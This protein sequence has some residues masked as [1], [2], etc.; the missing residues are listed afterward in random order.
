[1]NGA[2]IKASRGIAR[3]AFR[4]GSCWAT[5]QKTLNGVGRTVQTFRSLSK[6][7]TSNPHPIYPPNK[8][9]LALNTPASMKQALALNHFFL[10]H[11]SIPRYEK[12]VRKGSEYVVTLVGTG[13]DE[14]RDRRVDRYEREWEDVLRK[15]SLR[16]VGISLVRL[17][18]MG[19]K[20]RTGIDPTQ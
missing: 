19:L 12:N 17:R 10:S 4:K 9:P 18:M 16:S 14:K 5:R 3:A 8:I 11:S 20:R 13:D 15:V 1:M 2:R 7:T 6:G